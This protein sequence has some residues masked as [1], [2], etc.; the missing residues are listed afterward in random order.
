MPGDGCWAARED[1]TVTEH[2]AGSGDA[3]ID[4]AAQEL[5]ERE[6]PRLVA[7]AYRMTGTPDDA[8]DVVQDAWLRWQRSDRRA[9]ETPEA[10]LTTVTTRVAIDRL[11]SA[12]ARR[13]V[14]V[15]P[16]LPEPLGHGQVGGAMDGAM[17]A[18][19]GRRR[20]TAGHEAGDLAASDGDPAELVAASES[21]SISFLRVLETLAPVERA[22][23]LLHDVFGYPF[24]EVADAVQRSP[25]AARQ[26]AG[27]ARQRVRAGRPRVET[28]PEDVEALSAA[29]FGAVV[30]GDLERLT[31]MLT[32]DVVHVSDGGPDRHAARR[33]VVGPDRVARFLAN[34]ARRGIEPDDEFHEV[35]VNGQ[36][37]TYITRRGE[38]FLLI[39]LTW[40]G[41]RIAEVL[42]IVAPD[43]LARFHRRWTD[44]TLGR[45]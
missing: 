43:K 31:A 22:V 24:D 40:R 10:W 37:A 21:L 25:S 38:P 19:Q 4:A 18:A 15:G 44:V 5:F 9:I 13:E 8:D 7:L 34:L 2:P 14:Y 20:A 11:T 28:E 41:R 35:V 1:E 45:G 12:R 29:F 26:I 32:D 30:E 6:R 36:A 23:F 33:P 27:R 17:D 42:A 39:V 16:W 3:S